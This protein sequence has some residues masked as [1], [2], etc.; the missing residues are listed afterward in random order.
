MRHIDTADEA[1]ALAKLILSERKKPL[2]VISTDNAG[3]FRFAPDMI[4]REVG[5][6]VDVVTISHGLPTYTLS[7]GLPEKAN[8]HS[9]AA[10]AYPMDFGTDPDWRRSILRFPD[11]HT[12][13]DLIDDALAQV[14]ILSPLSHLDRRTWAHGIVERVSGGT[15]NIAKLS[16]GDLVRV[17][18]DQLPSYLSLADALAVGDRV[19]GWLTERDL[20][21]EPQEIDLS[22]FAEGTVTLARVTKVTAARANL[23]LHPGLRDGFILR[24]RD[25]VP[26]A[27]DGDNADV[28]VADLVQP[29][30]TVR[31]RVT[32]ANASAIS[33]ID[34]DP[35]APLVP[36]LS[37]LRGGSPWLQEGV[38]AP[39]STTVPANLP[40]VTEQQVDGPIPVV[41]P[42][43]WEVAQASPEPERADT[44]NALGEVRDELSELRGA[45]ARLS[46]ELRAG[47]DLETLDRLRDETAGLTAE[48]QRERGIRRERD[49]MIAGLRIELREARS[50]RGSEIDAQR[51]QRDAWPNAEDWFRFEVLAAWATR[52]IA[53]EKSQYPLA[54]FTLSAGF[55]DSLLPLDA[56]SLDKALRAVVDVLTGRVATMPA[57]QLHRLRTGLGGGDPFVVRAD[58][59]VCWRVAVEINVASARRL[60]YWQRPGFPLELSRVVLHDD[61]E[62]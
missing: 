24:R 57:R 30:H 52:T 28:S 4:A 6:D 48:L 62:P 14:T 61:F 35:A 2:L 10:R 26:G 49:A 40:A 18:A 17:V 50:Q 38:N 20:A 55:L 42:A 25:V 23:I 5:D 58:G 36:P 46:R 51:S 32:G 15:G 13:D 11:R 41:S 31:V 12:I 53:S 54:D 21:P 22:I 44:S 43:A 39:E 37:L 7:V 3:V 33:L 1:T 56:S 45:F 9:G 16:N 27:D 47:T 34:V 8:L 29:G 59:A 19:E 60:H